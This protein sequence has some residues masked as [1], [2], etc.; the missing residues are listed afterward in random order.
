LRLPL[1]VRKWRHDALVTRLL[2]VTLSMSQPLPPPTA[3]RSTI[4]ESLHPFVSLNSVHVADSHAFGPRADTVAQ[5]RS[6]V[7]TIER[8]SQALNHH[9]LS[10]WTE[11][12]LASS[13]RQHSAISHT[14]HQVRWL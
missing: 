10:P 4:Y 3:T 8:A 11:P 12:K 7:T 9:L 13:L 6:L 2:S 14:Y 1:S 5:L